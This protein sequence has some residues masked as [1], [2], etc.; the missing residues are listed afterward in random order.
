MYPNEN[1]ICAVSDEEDSLPLEIAYK[2]ARAELVLTTLREKVKLDPSQLKAKVTE[3]K[4]QLETLQAVKRS[5]TG[6]TKNI[7]NAKADL[8]SMETSIKNALED[9]FTLIKSG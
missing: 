5:M 6:A 4:G 1:L 8:S 7:E 9:I 3:I 2:V